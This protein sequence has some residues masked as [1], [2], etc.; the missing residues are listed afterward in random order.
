MS[1][2]G[3]V[4][5]VP[6]WTL[7]DKLRKAR[8]TANLHQSQLAAEIGISTSSIR[9]YEHARRAPR[10]AVLEAWAARCGVPVWWLEA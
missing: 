3:E 10:R 9:G 8:E 1:D 6:T 7:G 5:A 2:A 4:A